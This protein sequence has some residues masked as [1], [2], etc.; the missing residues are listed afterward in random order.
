MTH[1]RNRIAPS[2]ER[3]PSRSS[4]LNWWPWIRHGSHAAGSESETHHTRQ[5]EGLVVRS[6]VHGLRGVLP[7]RDR[8]SSQDAR[9][10]PSVAGCRCGRKWRAGIH[11]R[12]LSSRCSILV[13]RPPPAHI[14]VTEG[15]FRGR[16]M[17]GVCSDCVRVA[18]YGLFRGRRTATLEVLWTSGWPW[19]PSTGG[20]LP[21]RGPPVCHPDLPQLPPACDEDQFRFGDG[22]GGAGR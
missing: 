17:F 6:L 11:G 10:A 15:L 7:V 9:P 5:G 19:I 2:D 1:G 14:G 20:P 8:R 12:S 18:G 13:H 22:G 3:C 16:P 4:S 21:R